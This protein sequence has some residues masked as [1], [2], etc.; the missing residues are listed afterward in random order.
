VDSS[1]DNSA[2]LCPKIANIAGFVNAFFKVV[3][4]R[5]FANLIAFPEEAPYIL[6]EKH[7]ILMFVSFDPRWSF[8]RNLPDRGRVLEI[9]CGRGDNC[10]ALRH[11]HPNLEIHGLDL[12]DASQVPGDVQYLQHDLALLPLPYPAGSFSAILMIHVLE[13]LQQPLKLCAELQR[14]LATEGQ[15]YIEAPNYTSVFAPSFGWAR[16][17]HYPF[18]FYD[19]LEHHRPYTKQAL[20]EFIESCGLQVQK[21][22]NTRNWM[23]FPLDLVA[24]PYALAIGDRPQAVRRF[25]NLYGW[26]IFGTGRKGA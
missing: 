14:L 2:K 3:P 19:D 21:V 9:G 20:F 13:H 10:S 24:F 16:R 1:P 6:A 4:A 8:M 23:R 15:L 5:I 11:L 17:Q 7:P 25:W 12:L 22:G 26:C 18:N